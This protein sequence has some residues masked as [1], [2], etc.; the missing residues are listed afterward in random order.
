[1]TPLY[2]GGALGDCAVYA[3]AR[4]RGLALLFKGEDFARTDLEGARRL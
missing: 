4:S 2:L 3:L 1:M